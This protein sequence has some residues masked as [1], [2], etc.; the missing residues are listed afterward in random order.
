MDLHE[1]AHGVGAVIA[2]G[3]GELVVV[4]G[5]VLDRLSGIEVLHTGLYHRCNGV[6]DEIVERFHQRS[7]QAVPESDT[8]PL[9]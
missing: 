2:E 7:L 4:E 5:T 6:E 1:R 9:V 3:G 8:G